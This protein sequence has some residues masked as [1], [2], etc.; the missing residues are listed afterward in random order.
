MIAGGAA[1]EGREGSDS[2]GGVSRACAPDHCPAP[3]TARVS[4]VMRLAKWLVGA[5]ML[6]I[7][8][9]L[10]ALFG[11]TEGW[12][13][14]PVAPPGDARAFMDEAVRYVEADGP[15]NVALALVENGEL[16]DTYHS[17]QVGPDTLFPVGSLGKWLTAYG[18]M[19]LVQAGR[20]DL[21][22]PVD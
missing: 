12:F 6:M 14:R 10:V 7:A 19:T 17:G 18:V 4:R 22:A 8:W 15:A 21:D 11:A 2:G 16:F 13:R 9:S 20:I 3:L 1:V 5:L